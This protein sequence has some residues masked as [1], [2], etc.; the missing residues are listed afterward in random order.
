MTPMPSEKKETHIPLKLE[1]HTTVNGLE[2]SEM[3]MVFKN[4]QMVLNMKD[5]GKIIEHTEKA[6]S[7][8]LMVTS[9]MENG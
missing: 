9:M 3:G 6:S 5:S 2:A 1:Q 4:G 8:I 7:F